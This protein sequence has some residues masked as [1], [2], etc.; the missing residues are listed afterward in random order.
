MNLKKR[1]VLIILVISLLL[2]SS[3]SLTGKKGTTTSSKS[4]KSVEDIRV[5]T[6]G[7]VVSFLP[8]NPPDRLVVEEGAE[9]SIKVVLQ[10][11]NKGAYP[12][13]DE[14]PK[15]GAAP[16]PAKLYLSGY[17]QNI[18]TFP[19]REVDLSTKALE[20]RS[21]I[22][23]N[24]GI[25][26]VN[27]EGKVQA[28]V[29]NVERYEPILLATA[30]YYYNTI[31][32]P[33]V[34]IDTDPYSEVSTK[35]VCQVSDISLS[36]QGAPIAVT[37]IA[38]EALATKTQFRITIK[39]IGGGDAVK[40]TSE[41]KCDPLGTEKM[42]REDIDKVYVVGVSLGNKQLNCGPFAEGVIKS[43]SGFVRL[44]N[45][46][47]NLICEFPRQDYPQG[48]NTAYTTPLKIHLGY[49]YRT[50]IERKVLIKKEA[51]ASIGGSSSSGVA[52]SGSGAQVT[53]WT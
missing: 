24:G 30:C 37:K 45:G 8:N 25:D 1:L 10:V 20:G 11:N 6:Q 41:Q 32:S 34:C 44:I 12:Q 26:F 47:G 21:T 53:E 13:P 9:N 39:N 27:F 36:N 22:N 7:I 49:T 14:G 4:K 40:I 3:C 38:E 35:K 50:T 33:Q 17:D 28:E 19:Q 51:S 5:G 48:A 43:V 52:S 29:L 18:I 23:P 16:D 2:I 31:A 15:R 42:Q 46:E